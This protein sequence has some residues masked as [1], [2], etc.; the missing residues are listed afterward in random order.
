MWRYFQLNNYLVLFDWHVRIMC[1]WSTVRCLDGVRGGYCWRTRMFVA[2]FYSQC[3]TS[4]QRDQRDTGASSTPLSVYSDPAFL[5]WTSWSW[6]LDREGGLWLLGP[7]SV[8]ACTWMSW[9]KYHYTRYW[10]LNDLLK[11]A[12]MRVATISTEHVLAKWIG[13]YRR[14]SQNAQNISQRGY[15]SIIQWLSCDLPKLPPFAD[16]IFVFSSRPPTTRKLRRRASPVHNLAPFISILS[17]HFV[18]CRLAE[19]AWWLTLHPVQGSGRER[20]SQDL[21][22]IKRSHSARVL[23]FNGWR[24]SIFCSLGTRRSDKSWGTSCPHPRT[25]IMTESEWRLVGKAAVNSNSMCSHCVL[26]RIPTTYFVFFYWFH[27][28]QNTY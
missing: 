10:L 6:R 16:D 5:F 2:I 11:G 17:L 28:M 22:I 7:E 23:L 9:H 8:E 18:D 21:L 20:P 4:H 19:A 12:A 1:P 24:A 13:R 27:S 26:H 15:K 25:I 3:L 14:F